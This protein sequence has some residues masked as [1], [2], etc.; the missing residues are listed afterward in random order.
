MPGPGRIARLI[1]VALETVEVVAGVEVVNPVI[2]AVLGVP[3]RTI[4]AESR[5]AVFYGCLREL[6]IFLTP[7]VPPHPCKQ[8]GAEHARVVHRTAVGLHVICDACAGRGTL[9]R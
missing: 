1:D 3:P 6:E 2:G 7:R 8:R 4:G 9:T 5:A